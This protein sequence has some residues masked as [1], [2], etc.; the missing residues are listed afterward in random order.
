MQSIW[1]SG[2]LVDFTM[3]ARWEEKQSVFVYGSSAEAFF[4]ENLRSMEDA[5]TL[6]GLSFS[7]YMGLRRIICRRI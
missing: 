2:G 3:V 5:K 1:C 4:R 6:G 7:T